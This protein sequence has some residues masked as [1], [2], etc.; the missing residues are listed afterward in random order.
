MRINVPHSVKRHIIISLLTDTITHSN[1]A[2]SHVKS[3]YGHFK[4][5]SSNA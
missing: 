1:E 5:I 4:I 2:L 3:S